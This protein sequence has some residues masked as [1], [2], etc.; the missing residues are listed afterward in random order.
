MHKEYTKMLR[1]DWE[2]TITKLI[3]DNSNNLSLNAI[4][5]EIEVTATSLAYEKINLPFR[6]SVETLR[7]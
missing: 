5:E 3:Q 7:T 1:I 2:K 6:K 4:I